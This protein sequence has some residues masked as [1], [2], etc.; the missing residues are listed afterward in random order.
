M[1]PLGW[2]LMKAEDSER[3]VGEKKIGLKVGER[4]LEIDTVKRVC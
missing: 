1:A 2:T 3:R 4:Q